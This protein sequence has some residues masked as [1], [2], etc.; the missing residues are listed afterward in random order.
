VFSES[1]YKCLPALREIA[2][3]GGILARDSKLTLLDCENEMVDKL[4]VKID[5]IVGM[6]N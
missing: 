6:L 1:Q 5:E 4:I 3:R 2:E